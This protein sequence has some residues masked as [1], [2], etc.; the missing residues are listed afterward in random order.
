LRVARG[1]QNKVLEA[2]AMG[3]AVVTTA[4]AHEGLRAMPDRDLVVADDAAAFADAIVALLRD[5]GRCERIGRQARRCVE[6]NYDWD[7]N[8]VR[9]REA[10]LE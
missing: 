9:L 3:K 5:P 1:V 6:E 4:Q 8:L 2:M 7:R 10:G